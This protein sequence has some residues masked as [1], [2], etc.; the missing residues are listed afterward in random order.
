M[1]RRAT[2]HNMTV[3]VRARNQMRKGMKEAADEVRRFANETSRSG[4][5]ARAGMEGLQ[6]TA[7][8]MPSAFGKS[9]AA[10]MLMSSASGQASGA[11]ADVAA[12][13][14][15]LVSLVIAGGPLGIA[16]AGATAAIAGL[17][18]G[19]ETLTL[20]SRNY[21]NAVKSVGPVIDA[22]RDRIERTAEATKDYQW[23]IDNLGKS[24][25]Q[26]LREQI[27]QEKAGIETNKQLIAG[28]RERLQLLTSIIKRMEAS[29]ALWSREIDR[30]LE[31][32]GLADQTLEDLTNEAAWIEKQIKSTQLANEAR[33]KHIELAEKQIE[34]TKKQTALDKAETKQKENALQRRRDAE[35]IVAEEAALRAKTEADARKQEVTFYRD[36]ADAI[37]E[38]EQKKNQRVGE[39]NRAMADELRAARK[40]DTEL[41]RQATEQAIA[42]R[43]SEAAAVSATS[44]AIVQ[45]GF[46]EARSARDTAGAVTAF[47]RSA[48]RDVIQILAVKASAAAAEKVYEMV[49]MPWAIPAS[50]AAAA[51]AYG[52]I[53][54]LTAKLQKGGFVTGGQPGRDSV[55]AMLTPGEYVMSTSQVDAFA[56]FA[57][58]I[59]G[60]QQGQQLTGIAAAPQGRGGGTQI[61]NHFSSQQMFPDQVVGRKAMRRQARSVQHL[62]RMGMWPG[63]RE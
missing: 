43:R 5:K 58:K 39:I 30:L 27:T 53:I 18:A 36:L 46:N 48:A 31:Q 14:T 55:P 21:E 12:K 20:A 23:Q 22:M 7:N 6:K 38:I 59:L 32:H 49:P 44:T 47:A 9:S 33:Q 35:K 24:S 37:I 57:A 2:Q 26:M 42:S 45:K 56:A 60:Q 1:P 63:M 8:E 50:A 34:F 15:D 13:I 25:V 41:Q 3:N 17:T 29:G 51:A 10:L 62:Q 40:K 28:D 19:Y 54:A 52:S 16:I 61:V 4:G 11:F